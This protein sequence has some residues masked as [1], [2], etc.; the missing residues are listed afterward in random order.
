MN[1]IAQYYIA[2]LLLCIFAFAVTPFSQKAEA[3]TN[4]DITTIRGT[5]TGPDGNPF[6]FA[7][8]TAICDGITKNSITN[9]Q[10]K[11]LF[12]FTG[13]D[14]C[15]QGDTV[16]ITVSKDGV[17]GSTDSVVQLLRD[18]RFVDRNFSAGSFALNVPEYGLA[19][20]TITVMASIGA[21]LFIRSRKNKLAPV[22][23]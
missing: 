20:G 4:F 22:N 18:G 15:T 16:H 3:A 7:R 13:R 14:T 11:Y 23:A 8:V 10:G 19:T 12:I 1:K 21:F 9:G 17:T 6:K 5:I 2:P